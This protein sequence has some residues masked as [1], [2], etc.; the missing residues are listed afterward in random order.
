MRVLLFAGL[1]ALL[2]TGCEETKRGG[3]G[4]PGRNNASDAS[5]SDASDASGGGDDAGP[6]IDLGPG[7]DV[8]F[9]DA[10][11]GP[12][13]TGA[14]G[15]DTGPGP[16]DT[17][18]RADAMVGGSDSGGGMVDAGGGADAAPAP[19]TGPRP[20]AGFQDTSCVSDFG[21]NEACGGS[22]VG[23]WTFVS[24]C[25]GNAALAPVIAI[26]PSATRANETHVT[27]GTM[28]FTAAGRYLRSVRD[29]I[30][31]DITVPPLCQFPG[32]P[33][34]AVAG[35]IQSL[36]P[37]SSSVCTADG[38]MNC[39][40]RTTIDRTISD[41]GNYTTAP[42]SVVFVTEPLSGGTTRQEHWYCATGNVLKFRGEVVQTTDNGV[43][44]VLTR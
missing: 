10:G 38:Q 36:L 26:C 14:G 31:A 7:V 4:F 2:V 3:G 40:C 1:A 29:V 27:T 9:F 39:L 22:L 33:C 34:S 8:G 11:G 42:G 12:A 43:A 32:Q 18:P 5:A 6:G 16:S 17:G 23:N 21:A 30:S 20:D 19:D 25:L 44:Y 24:G 13:D 28:E 37:N 41:E 15:S 35:S